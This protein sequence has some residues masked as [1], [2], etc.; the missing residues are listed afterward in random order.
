MLTIVDK[1]SLG[2]LGRIKLFVAPSKVFAQ[3]RTLRLYLSMPK[4]KD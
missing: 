3:R 4:T 1:I 2:F